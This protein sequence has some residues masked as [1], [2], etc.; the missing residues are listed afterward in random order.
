MTN[1]AVPLPTRRPPQPKTYP[2]CSLKKV[3]DMIQT[4]CGNVSIKERHGSG[5][6]KVILLPE[7][8]QELTTIVSYGRRSPMNRCEQKLVGMGHFLLNDDGAVIV[9]V[10]HFMELQ[11]MNRSPVSASGLGPNGENNPG[12]DFLEYHRTEFLRDEARFN[13]DAYGCLVDPF[14]KLCGPSEF[15]MDAHTHPDLG[16]FYSHADRVNGA[17]RA[18]SSPVCILVC[19]PIRKKLLGSIGRELVE[20]EILVYSRSAVPRKEPCE[21]PG[22]A[23]CEDSR[24]LPP[25]DGL[26]QLAGQCLRTRGFSGNVRLRSRLDGKC[27]LSIQMVIPKNRKE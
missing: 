10:S 4:S 11:T 20:A 27:C 18:G 14:L 12:L 9:I 15:V 5:R 6:D 2:I 8:E 1:H 23:P 19:D 21:A 25:T 22:E 3:M 24:L 17:A 16:V 26:V 13:T 7:A